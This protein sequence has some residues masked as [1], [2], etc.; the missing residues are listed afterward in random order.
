MSVYELVYR[1]CGELLAVIIGVLLLLHHISFSAL[2]CRSLGQHIDMLTSAAISNWTATNVGGIAPLDSRIDPV[3]ATLAVVVVLLG[4]LDPPQW[5]GRRKIWLAA[6]S[7]AAMLGA[8]LF[9]FVVALFH[10]HFD[11]WTGVD[12]FFPSGLRGVRSS[13]QINTVAQKLSG[14][15][16][17]INASNLQR[18]NSRPKMGASTASCPHLSLKSRDTV[19][20]TPKSGGYAYSRNSGKLLTPLC[21]ILTDFHNYFTDRLILVALPTQC[22][23]DLRMLHSNYLSLIIRSGYVYA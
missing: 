9:I 17:V 14:Q 23:C 3:G 6:A 16:S 19:P 22:A 18:R 12:N 4:R 5:L 7:T 1:N 21:Q 11:N 20:L 13:I 15:V 10:L 8:L 2:V